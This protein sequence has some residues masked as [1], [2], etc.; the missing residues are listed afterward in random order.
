MHR[1]EFEEYLLLYGADINLWPQEIRQA[2]LEAMESSAELQAFYQDHDNFEKLLHSRRYEEPADNLAQRIISVS[3]QQRQNAPF[4]IGSFISGLINEFSV[5]RPA[6]VALSLM[7]I[8]ALTI[9]FTI[10]F[11]NPSGSSVLNNTEET[12][13]QAFLFDEGDVI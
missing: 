10:G 6:L 7:M 11:T 8:L 5:P 13:L 4:S 1:K 9:G 3:L 2:G 12:N